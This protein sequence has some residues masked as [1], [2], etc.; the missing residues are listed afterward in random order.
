MSWPGSNM[1][2]KYE[3]YLLHKKLHRTLLTAMLIHGFVILQMSILGPSQNQMSS[4]LTYT[5]SN[6]T[7]WCQ[8]EVII[9]PGSGVF[10]TF[11]GNMPFRTI[12]STG[13]KNFW[14]QLLQ[15]FPVTKYL[16]AI[17][18]IRYDFIIHLHLLGPLDSRGW[19]T[20]LGAQQMLMHRK[21]CLIPILSRHVILMRVYAV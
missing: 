7:L 13:K 19:N 17:V 2:V 20:S 4:S 12:I 21:S 11:L 18:A 6:V 15:S 8:N 1:E 5:A 10:K 14:K 3:S 16:Y 9:W